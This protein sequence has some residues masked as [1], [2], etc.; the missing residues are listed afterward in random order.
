MHQYDPI[1]TGKR[2][3][4]LVADGPFSRHGYREKNETKLVEILM[5]IAWHF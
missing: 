3:P 4:D 5:D 2:H 1:W